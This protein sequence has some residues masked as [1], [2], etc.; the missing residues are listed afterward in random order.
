M[1]HFASAV[2]VFSPPAA[3]AAISLPA[4]AIATGLSAT[5]TCYLLK[6]YALLL[7]RLLLCLSVSALLSLAFS[8][9]FL[10]LF[11]FLEG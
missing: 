4:P 8:L 7:L 1:S 3:L 11:T 5:K 6:T 2:Q 10:H 9:L